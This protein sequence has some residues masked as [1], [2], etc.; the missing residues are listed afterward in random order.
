M[1]DWA[2]VVIRFAL[3]TDLMLL[4]GLAAFPLYSFT[5]GERE[6]D[7]ALPLT[8]VLTWL[9]LAGLVFSALGFTIS[10]AAMMG[11]PVAA[12]DVPML[13]SMARE[14]EQGTAWLARTVSLAVIFGFLITLRRQPSLRYGIA[15]ACGAVALATLLWSGHAAATEGPL[16][17]VHR[18]SDIVHMMAAA[19]WTGGIASFGL[20]LSQ[21]TPGSR[22]VRLV[23]R[24]LAGF[25]SV[26]TVAVVIIGLTGLLNGYAILGTDA[27]AFV[28]SPYSIL[29]AIKVFL[30]AAMLSLAANNRWR[31]TPLLSDAHDG[32]QAAW[33]SLRISVALE[34]AA[35]AAILVL[36]AWLG[37][38]S[39]N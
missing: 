9:A 22:H 7:I 17:T 23:A 28:R 39:P 8:P 13:L 37:T 31:L 36:V 38:L 20:L 15:L 6:Q 27:M 19:I 2:L 1:T 14:T 11:V 30:F 29:L 33:S 34:T 10:S 3:Y 18:I 25:A 26:G 24:T 5:R 4:V 16:G 32:T 12:I 21:S 35:S